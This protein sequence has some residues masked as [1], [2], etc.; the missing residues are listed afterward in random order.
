MHVDLSWKLSTH[1]EVKWGCLVKSN[2]L[3]SHD[4]QPIR[5]LHPWDFP[6]KSTGVGCPFLLRGIFPTKGSN[7]GL[8]HCRQTLYC[9]SHQATHHNEQY[10]AEGKIKNADLLLNVKYRAS[11]Q[12]TVLM[13]GIE[14]FKFPALFWQIIEICP[15]L[16]IPLQEAKLNG[17]NCLFFSSS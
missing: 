11:C 15:L 10:F 7:P 5:S 4:L 12:L 14:H 8:P 17:L 2:S 3:W 16:F 1:H 6:G 9:L 13:A